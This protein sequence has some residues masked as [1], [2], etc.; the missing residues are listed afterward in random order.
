MPNTL[1]V[2]KT[3]IASMLKSHAEA[4][5]ERLHDQYLRGSDCDV[6]LTAADHPG[7]NDSGAPNDGSPEKLNWSSLSC[8]KIVL[9]AV[10]SF[11]IASFS[12]N[13]RTRK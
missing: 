13:L 1:H 9:R 7:Q 5:L 6:I 2:D 4:V 11:L 12:I 8:H 3:P 10:S